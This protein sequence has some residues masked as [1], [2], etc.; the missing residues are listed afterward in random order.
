MET[1]ATDDFFDFRQLGERVDLELKTALGR[2]GKG[3][4]P[5]S[6]WET[7]SAMANTQGGMI[8]LGVKQQG[9]SFEVTGVPDADKVVQDLWN[10]VNNPQT[11]SANILANASVYTRD[12]PGGRL[13]FIEVPRASRKHRPVHLGDNPFAGT[14][15]RNH[16]G[17]YR[18]PREVVQQMLGEQVN[19]TRDG[20]LLE[21]YSF[22]DLHLDTLRV[23][24]QHFANRQ[25]THVL[26]DLENVEFLRQIGAWSR[27]R[28]SGKEGPTLAGLLMFGRL[29]S[30]LDAVPHY[31]VDSRSAPGP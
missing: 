30:I 14:Y 11:V 3:Q 15:R 19:D 18:C 10:Q 26:N 5:R 27:D 6:L 16:E 12:Y 8:V 7:Y 21:G 31:V 9:D 20:A 28:Q 2:D 22:A 25:P 13:I 1:H 4:L 17:D 29:R 24:R 23:Y